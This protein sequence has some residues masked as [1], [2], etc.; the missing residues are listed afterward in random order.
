[1]LLFIMDK[2]HTRCIHLYTNCVSVDCLCFYKNV[3]TEY[4]VERLST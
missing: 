2:V 3:I 1:M 4:A